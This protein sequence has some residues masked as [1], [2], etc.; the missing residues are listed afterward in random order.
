MST[1]SS[2]NPSFRVFEVDAETML[3]VKTHTYVFDVSQSNP[4]WQHDHEYTEY[5]EMTDLSPSSFD[6]LSA[7][8]QN[9]E[10][11]SVKFLN[12]KLSLSTE[13]QNTSCDQTCRTNLYCTTRNS[14]FLESKD[15]QGLPRYDMRSDPITTMGEKMADPWYYPK[16][17][18]KKQ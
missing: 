10:S 3:P 16:S 2:N 12:A 5:Y 18:Q 6:D 11:L 17:T 9:D 15:C 13:T 8:M 4:V 14:V 7:R 1:F